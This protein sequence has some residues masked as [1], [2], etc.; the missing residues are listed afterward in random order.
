MRNTAGTHPNVNKA[1]HRRTR[2]LADQAPL[3][4][5]QMVVLKAVLSQRS[6]GV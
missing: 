6:G 1:I 3:T 4:S 5:E 2:D